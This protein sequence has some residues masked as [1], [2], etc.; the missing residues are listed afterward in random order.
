MNDA[1]APLQIDIRNLLLRKLTIFA[2][3]SFLPP[4]FLFVGY[5]VA[6]VYYAF[7][8]NYTSQPFI[9]D[10]TIGVYMLF[11]LIVCEI[12]LIYLFIFTFNYS[13]RF[14]AADVIMARR[15][16]MLLQLE[17]FLLVLNV[18][19]IT[20]ITASLIGNEVTL[21]GAAL[22]IAAVGIGLLAFFSRRR[23]NKVPRPPDGV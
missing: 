15:M 18:L 23:R 8:V 5:L 4:I 11:L 3:F 20:Y 10:T 19:S 12:A 7:I 17:L 21:I 16:G 6:N 2:I 14:M 22:L 1:L 9:L 13:M